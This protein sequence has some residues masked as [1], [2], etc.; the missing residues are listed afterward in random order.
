MKPV[1]VSASFDDLRSRH[2]RLLQEAARTG[3]VCVQLWDDDVVRAATSAEPKF[4]LPERRYFVESVRFVAQVQPL[5]AADRGREA[6]LAVNQSVP[7]AAWFV[8]ERTANAVDERLVRASGGEYRVLSDAELAGFP[9]PMDVA[10]P[11]DSPPQPKVIVTGCYDWLH[12]GHVR[13]FE[14]VAELGELHVVVGHNANVRQLKGPHHPLFPEQERRYMAGA[15]RFVRRAY[16]SSGDG[17]LDAE[18]E[19]AL[20]RPDVYAVNED[21]DRPEKR[22]FCERHGIKYHVL[23]RRPKPGLEGRSSTAL[24]GF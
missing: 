8:D 5:A 21:G 10:G 3:P 2:I 22:T 17:W 12:T 1:Y 14:E 6:E 11:Q 23:T 18:P 19:I 20:I 7:G 15:I 24:R 13:F 4:P 16:V 9:E